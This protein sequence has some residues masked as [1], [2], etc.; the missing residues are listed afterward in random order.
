[1]SITVKFFARLREQFNIDETLIEAQPD[2]TALQLWQQLTG[3]AL[4][5]ANTLIAVNQEYASETAVIHDN[6]E[7]AFFPPVTGG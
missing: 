2:L 5:P 6:D 7:V 4:L 3:Q 1:M